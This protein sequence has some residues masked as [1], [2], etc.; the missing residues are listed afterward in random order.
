MAESSDGTVL[1]EPPEISTPT[2]TNPTN[3]PN[4]STLDNPPQ[5]IPR[6]HST[7][8]VTFPASKNAATDPSHALRRL[9]AQL[10]A[11]DNDVLIMAFNNYK[12]FS[13]PSDIPADK[14]A[15]EEA[16]EV[17]PSRPR[18]PRNTV[19]VCFRVIG[20][21][22]LKHYK[23]TKSVY[24]YL[25]EEK[26][27]LAPHEFKTIKTS[28]IGWIS[29][30][31]PRTTWHPNFAKDLQANLKVDFP[32]SVRKHRVAHTSHK[33]GKRTFSTDALAIE[34]PT[35]NA[36]SLQAALHKANLPVERF[37]R[38]VPY[39]LAKAGM[40]DL[41]IEQREGATTATCS[42]CTRF[43]LRFMRTDSWRRLYLMDK[44]AR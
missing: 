2:P 37:G 18:A 10:H 42:P 29:E 36:D 6:V 8:K 43:Q 39:G 13:K 12:T 25:C 22:N 11:V 9:F 15:F 31:T 24:D 16:F 41:L 17:Q 33:D 4:P 5:P 34:C 7:A 28:T 32:L 19:A 38:F 20:H 21:H 35:E 26:I 1:S 27:F 23:Y 14:K 30:K 44:Q 40:E 3:T